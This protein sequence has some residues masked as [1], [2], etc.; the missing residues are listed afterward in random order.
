MK[1]WL[2]VLILLPATVAAQVPEASS[3][4]LFLPAGEVALPAIGRMPEVQAA[5]AQLARA[6]ADARLRRVGSHETTLTMIPQRRSIQ[7]GPTFNEWEADLSRAIRW[8]HKVRLDREIGAA[9]VEAAQLALADS[10]HAG[11]RRL[12]ALWSAWQRARATVGQQQAQVASWERD[13]QAIARRLELGDAARRDLVAAEAALAQARAAVLRAEAGLQTARLALHST[14][15]DLPLPEH[16]T[17]G[18]EPPPLEGSDTHWSEL[19]VARSHEIGIAA[20]LAQ[21]REAEAR[22][23]RAE[24]LPDPT[25]GVRVLDDLGGRE[26]AAG[27][28]VSIPLGV[29]QRSASAAAAG[30]DALQAQ[31]ELALVRRDIEH[32]AVTRVAQM[33]AALAIWTQQQ[34]ASRATSDSADK[35][36]RAYALGESGLA[37]LLVARRTALEAALAE[38]NAAIDA[39]EA[40][41]LVRIDAHDLWHYH[42]GEG[43]DES[44][45]VGPALPLP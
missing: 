45:D 5:M 36:D 8:P 19:I 12:L 44:H 29:R 28:I 31:A 1:G 24:R 17:P 41:A 14:F 27:L 42:D 18:G 23:A 38:R 9:G 37:E 20:A 25:I 33:R 34:Q 35:T 16:G 15:P 2:A 21:Q 10:Y 6:E 39:I 30:A 13:R 7:G 11:A 4:G 3:P 22:R 32:E 43:D 40:T 26:R